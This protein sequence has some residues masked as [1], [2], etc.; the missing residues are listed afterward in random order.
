MLGL[1]IKY[2]LT[3]TFDVILRTSSQKSCESDVIVLD[4]MRS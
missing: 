4:L 1:F 3:V 2:I